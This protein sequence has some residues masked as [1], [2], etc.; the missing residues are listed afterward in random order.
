M[1]DPLISTHPP[2]NL[3]LEGEEI[4]CDAVVILGEETS[5]NDEEYFTS[6]HQNLEPD[7]AR[8]AD[9]NMQHLGRT[10][11]RLFRAAKRNSTQRLDRRIHGDVADRANRVGISPLPL[12]RRRRLPGSICVACNMVAQHRTIQR[13][14][15]A[16]GM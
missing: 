2:P 9:S 15:L 6:N 16:N 14:R 12:A 10:R 7:T 5:K 11:P 13:P 1:G 8:F 3:P 4:L